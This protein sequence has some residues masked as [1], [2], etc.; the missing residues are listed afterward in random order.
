M[1]SHY[2]N[3]HTGFCIAFDADKPLKLSS[4][5][6]KVLYDN[7][8]PEINLFDNS[9]KNFLRFFITK[10]NDWEYEAEYRI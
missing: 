5:L 10:S 1:W 7:V 4:S 3:S 6:G 9:T 2:S 8:Y